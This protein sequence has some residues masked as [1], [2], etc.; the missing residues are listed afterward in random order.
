MLTFRRL[1][2]TS[3][4]QH[5]NLDVEFSPGVVGIIGRNGSGKSNLV[6][7]LFRALTGKSLN[8]GKKE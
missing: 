1:R 4:C 3:F 2:A 8:P 7:G 5:K 6:K